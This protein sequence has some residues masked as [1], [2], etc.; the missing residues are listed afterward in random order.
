MKLLIIE[1]DADDVKEII[2]HAV[3][4]QWEMECLGFKEGL[5][6]M[7]SYNPDIVILDIKDDVTNNERFGDSI[8][9]TYR[10]QSSVRL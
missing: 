5:N 7:D 4:K 1:D 3:E 6:A 8:L 2:D 9:A 10:N